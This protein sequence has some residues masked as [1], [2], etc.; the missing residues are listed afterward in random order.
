MF[1]NNYYNLIKEYENYNDQKEKILE[2]LKK[3]IIRSNS[4]LEGNCFY[5]HK[6]MN[7]HTNLYTKQLNLF[8]AG[9]QGTNK[10][11]EIGFNA[12]HSTMLML[13]GRD[14]TQLDFTIFDIGHHSYTKPCFDYIQSK[15]SNVNFKFIEGD[16]GITMPNWINN[17]K[18][19]KNTY[20]IIH[21]DGGHYEHCIESDLRN[22]DILIK[23][24]G[25]IIIDD[26][27]YSYINKHINMYLTT[28]NY[29]ELEIFKTVGY[30]HRV[31]KKIEFYLTL[32]GRVYSWENDSIKFLENGQMNAF[33]Y[34]NYLYVDNYIVKAYFGNNEHLLRFNENYTKFVSIRKSDNYVVKGN[35]KN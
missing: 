22:A 33:G 31:I 27:H 10:I 20:D 9:K 26:T 35:L 6:T 29:M 8:W 24:N 16:S 32:I 12:G 19:E 25:I 3:I 1:D 14:K 18:S 17:N 21:I 13:L 7:L 28:G 34:G 4:I 2:D 11:C 5:F 30:P 23:L 15:F